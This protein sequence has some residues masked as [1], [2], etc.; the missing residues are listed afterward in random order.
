MQIVYTTV[1]LLNR[2]F[3]HSVYLFS[4]VRYRFLSLQYFQS[5][6][7]RTIKRINSGHQMGKV[8]LFLHEDKV[9]SYAYD[10]LVTI[11]KMLRHDLE[12][13]SIVMP[14]HRRDGGVFKAYIDPF[15]KHVL[16]LG[17][18]GNLVC[19]N[20]IDVDVDYEKEK[21]LI[22]LVNSSRYAAMFARPTLGFT[23]RGIHLIILLFSLEYIY[24]K[25]PNWY[26]I[27]GIPEI[28]CTRRN[29]IQ[30]RKKTIEQHTETLILSEC[31]NTK[32]I[33]SKNICL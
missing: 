2:F 19:T 28:I 12:I 5:D 18:D 26:L 13:K 30:K 1:H 8:L 22:D 4:A 29:C 31:P 7:A 6:A 25:V 21:R 16:T 27:C 24:Y 17:R 11:H 20:L 15:N 3:R 9:I 32:L 23:L 10:G 14:H 33:Y